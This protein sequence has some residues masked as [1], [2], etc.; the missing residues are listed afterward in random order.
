M[1][2][3]KPII[4]YSENYSYIATRSADFSPT[5]KSSKFVSSGRIPGCAF[6]QFTGP[7]S[8]TNQVT[9]LTVG[10][11]ALYGHLSNYYYLVS[12]SFDKLA[13]SRFWT[14]N[15]IENKAYQLYT[16]SGKKAKLT[17]DKG[18]FKIFGFNFPIV[19]EMPESGQ[20]TIKVEL[21]QQLTT[22]N[23]LVVGDFCYKGTCLYTNTPPVSNIN[24]VVSHE[25][26][27]YN[28]IFR[29][30]YLSIFELPCQKS[31]KSASVADQI[32]TLDVKNTLDNYEYLLYIRLCAAPL[33]LILK[34]TTSS[35]LNLSSLSDIQGNVVINTGGVV[36]DD[37]VSVKIN[38]VFEYQ[39][40]VNSFDC[41]DQGDS[42]SIGMYTGNNVMKDKQ[43]K[44]V[45]ASPIFNGS[46]I[47]KIIG[48]FTVDVKKN[49][50]ISFLGYGFGLPT[51]FPAVTP[52]DITG[53][54]KIGYI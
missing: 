49:Q 35:P 34:S 24:R 43:G 41:D 25:L 9:F 37:T 12:W 14:I 44:N 32:L 45:Q 48:D 13:S 54:I 21:G 2:K 47:V 20:V 42:V 4:A 17:T 28:K 1:D 51:G 8:H 53:N 31:L 22:N 36:A 52:L 26:E 30:K 33:R 29:E 6:T 23:P 11:E 16:T 15:M 5:S 3:L 10:N 39:F 7:G 38:L 46:T 27:M 18:C 50:Q 19:L 40:P